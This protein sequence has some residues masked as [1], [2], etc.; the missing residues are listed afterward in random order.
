MTAL[1]RFVWMFA[2]ALTMLVAQALREVSEEVWRD[3]KTAWQRARKRAERE[4]DDDDTA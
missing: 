1:E 4:D 3:I 2:G